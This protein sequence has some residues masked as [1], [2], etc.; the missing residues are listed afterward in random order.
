MTIPCEIR[1]WLSGFSHLF[2]SLK[3][4]QCAV[5]TRHMKTYYTILDCPEDAS[6]AELKR[7]YFAQIRRVHPDKIDDV[8]QLDESLADNLVTAVSK[9]WNL[10]KDP[11]SRKKY[12]CWLREQRLKESRAVIGEEVKLCELDI[13]EPC[14][15]GGYFEV[16]EAELDQIVDSALFDCAHCSL[17]LKIYA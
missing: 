1:S 4:L 7:A 12:D 14:R 5:R 11:E 10:L 8:E 6:L 13:D 2:F 9:A 16:S 3:P 15:C 17:C